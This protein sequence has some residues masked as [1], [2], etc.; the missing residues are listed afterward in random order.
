MR[1]GV[2]CLRPPYQAP[3]DRAR[4][5]LSDDGDSQK[6]LRTVRG[7]ESEFV[8]SMKYGHWHRYLH[9]ERLLP[10]QSDSPPGPPE[11]A[12]NSPGTPTHRTSCRGRVGYFRW[13]DRRHHRD[14]SRFRD[15]ARHRQ[16]FDLGYKDLDKGLP[17]T[18]SC[19]ELKAGYVV[20][21]SVRRAAGCVRT[22]SGLVDGATGVANFGRPLRPRNSRVSLNFADEVSVVIAATLGVKMQDAALRNS[23][24]REVEPDLDSYDCMLR[25]RRFARSRY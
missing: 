4:R 16:R 3:S 12:S 22:S 10:F 11:K 15:S 23:R 19:A 13:F 9:R 6:Y 18:L 8:G 25:A 17:Q 24:G 7:Q 2:L 1:R 20:K 14:L 21:G 5:A